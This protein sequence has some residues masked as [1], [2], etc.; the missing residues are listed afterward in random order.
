MKFRSPSDEPV[1]VSLTNGHSAV[2]GTEFREL[3]DIL[4]RK[5][6]EAAIVRQLEFQTGAVLTP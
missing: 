4:H 2:I 1:Y 5:A 6:R 3:P